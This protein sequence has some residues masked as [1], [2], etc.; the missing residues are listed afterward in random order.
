MWEYISA[1]L[2]DITAIKNREFY[3]QKMSVKEIYNAKELAKVCLSSSYKDCEFN[4]GKPSIKN[5]SEKTNTKAITLLI[6]PLNIR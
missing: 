4:H 6:D 2:G 1:S 3:A 5:L